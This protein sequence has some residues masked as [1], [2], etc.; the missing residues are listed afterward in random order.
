MS[1]IDST[2]PGERHIVY[3]QHIMPL[4]YRHSLHEHAFHELN[5]LHTIPYI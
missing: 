2:D 5:A 3:A 1:A 4:E